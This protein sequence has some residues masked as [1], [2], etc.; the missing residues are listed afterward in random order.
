MN[1]IEVL[2]S[3]KEGVIYECDLGFYVK[4]YKGYLLRLTYNEGWKY[5]SIHEH[6][7][8]AKYK[9]VSKRKLDELFSNYVYQKDEGY[10]SK[11]LCLEANS[12][13]NI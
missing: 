6:Y 10:E 11:F 5:C 13:F 4:K 2:K 12:E 9:T 8:K 1:L 3:K 7:T